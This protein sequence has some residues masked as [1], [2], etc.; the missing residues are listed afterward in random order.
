MILTSLE[1]F[2]FLPFAFPPPASHLPSTIL[3]GSLPPPLPLFVNPDKD[4][5]LD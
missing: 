4:V 3:P 1:K 5:Q 2:L